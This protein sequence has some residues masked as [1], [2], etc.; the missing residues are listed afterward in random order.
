MSDP[1]TLEI[2]R[3]RLLAVPELIDKNVARTAFSPII[4]DYK[5]YAVGIVDCEGRLI[6]QC[7]GGITVFV[8]NALG[9]AVRDGLQIYGRSRIYAGDILIT[10][11][12]GTMGQHLNNVVMY[13]PIFCGDGD[14]LFGFMAV[15]FHWM[16]VGGAIVGSCVSNTTTDIYQEGI[17]FRSV[18]LVERGVSS[19]EMFR[20]IQYNTRFPEMV[21]GDV[22]AQIAGCVRGK[23]LVE[24]IIQRYGAQTVRDA[25]QNMWQQSERAARRA[26]SSL[27]NGVYRA[28]SFLDDDG[29]HIGKPVPI[30]VVVMVEDDELTV[31]LSGVADQL[32]GPLNSGL[33]GGAVAAVRIACKYLL[34]PDEPANDGAFRPLRITIPERKFLSAGPEAPMGGSGSTLPSV[35][36][37]I[38]RAFAE[39]APDL[40]NAGHHGTFGIHMFFGRDPRSGRFFKHGNTAIGGWGASS[41]A[42]GEGPFRSMIHADTFEVPVEM[43]EAMFP[44]R[45]DSFTLRP[46]SGGAGRHRGGLGIERSYTALAAMSFQASFERSQCRPWGL[47]SGQPGKPGYVEAI[48]GERSVTLTKGQLEL[49]EGDRII[50]RTG[51]GGGYG[52]PKQRQAALI[53]RDLLEGYVSQDGLCEYLAARNEASA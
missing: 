50:V 5:D 44:I 6:A 25:V 35:I 14:D 2:V 45:I 3:Q 48:Q 53:E 46:D 34:T 36:D 26:I 40:V 30:E 17:Q 49:T 20:I 51:G 15:V 11:H 37:T 43:Q 18:K 23:A 41:R 27:P 29:I 7:K 8:A 19:E 10:N 38:I 4:A 22:Q 39:V 13:T 1:I 24:E 12:A 47:F 9:V 16:D 52:D 33:Q 31:D 42:D 32:P 28:S 21:L